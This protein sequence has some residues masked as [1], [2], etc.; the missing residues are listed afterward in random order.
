MYLA[1]NTKGICDRDGFEYPLRELRKEWTGLMVCR[2]CYDAKPAQLTPPRIKP[3][4]IPLR[5]A[6]PDNQTDDSEALTDFLRTLAASGGQPTVMATDP[7][8][9]A[10]SANGSPTLAGTT[11][12][13][14]DATRFNLLGG[15][16]AVAGASY[17]NN[18]M[19]KCR[20]VTYS[21]DGTSY[22]ELVNAVE[23]DH[24]GDAL[25][26]YLKGT[27]AVCRLLVDGQTTTASSTLR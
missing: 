3:E 15:S 27:G 17:P 22:A 8:F 12:A 6:R 11:Y 4:G 24:T 16:W 14:T 18:E 25:E 2:S 10:G 19:G 21:A 26:F 7:T 13:W 23:F 1:G 5:D 9:T 20:S